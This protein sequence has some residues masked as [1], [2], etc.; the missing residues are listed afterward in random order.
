MNYNTQ[1]IDTLSKTKSAQ[2][3][4]LFR[5]LTGQSESV[6][7]EAVKLQGDFASKHRSQ[8]NSQ[9]RAEYYYSMFVLA[10]VNMHWIET[11]QSQKV[12]LESDQ[13]RKISEIRISRIRS[14]RKQRTSP[15]K[16]LIRV[17]FYEEIKTLK[18]E[19]LSWRQIADYIRLHHK[20]T[21]TFGYLRD[22][23]NELTIEREDI[24]I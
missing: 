21:F 22:C 24:E 8:Y 20:K 13:A 19:G 3:T 9:Y 2:R 16:D 5:W 18:N 17:R 4:M 1:Y 23:Y 15:K 12:A 10:L 6:K 14:Q 7:I 11:A